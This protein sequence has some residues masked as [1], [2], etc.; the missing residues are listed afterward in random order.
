M[1]PQN[2]ANNRVGNP[3]SKD[4][5]SKIEEGTLSCENGKDIANQVVRYGI[6]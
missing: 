6:N 1:N 2:G 4:F 3:L 5:L